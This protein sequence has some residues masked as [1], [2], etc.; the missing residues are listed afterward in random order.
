MEWI[1]LHNLST[2]IQDAFATAKRRGMRYVWIDSL[3][4]MLDDTDDWKLESVNMV[5]YYCNSV[6]SVVANI[7]MPPLGVFDIPVNGI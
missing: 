6:V 1:P 7:D 4:I 2:T 3:C 5:D